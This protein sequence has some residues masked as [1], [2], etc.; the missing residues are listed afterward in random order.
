MPGQD[1]TA[2]PKI[3][4]VGAGPTGLALAL[5]LARSGVGSV[6]LERKAEL[7]PH[8]RATV[9]LP[10]TM[11]ILAQW[12]L[13]EQFAAAGNCVPHIRLRHAPEGKQFA[14]FDFTDLTN[15]TAT[16]F[17]LALP[18]DQTEH[19]LLAAVT[20]TGM[21]DV[22]FNTEVLGFE[23]NDDGV[24]LRVRSSEGEHEL[25][26]TY[27]VGADGAHSVVRGGLGFELE[28]KTYPTRA[29]L[30][31]VRVAPEKD[32]TEFWPCL[33]NE[34]LV[35]GIRF[36]GGIFR[37]VADSVDESVTDETIGDHVNQL[38]TRLFGLPPVETIWQ[39]TYR[40]HQRC[41]PRFR[42]GRVLLAGD[43]A[44]LNSPAGGQGMN[45]GIQDAHN[46]AWKLAMAVSDQRADVDALLESYAEE[47][48]GYVNEVVLPT[49]DAMERFESGPTFLR[50]A[51]VWL[52]DKLLGAGESAPAVARRVS[53]LDVVYGRSA[54]IQSDAPVGLRLPDVIGVHGNR[55]LGDHWGA[56]VL[57]AGY[58]RAAG[59]LGSALGLPV[60]DGDVAALA[61]FF[62]R[63]RFVALVRPD[64]VVAWISSTESIDTVAC[65]AAL[66]L[67]QQPQ[68]VAADR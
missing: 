49:T 13:R 61:A 55:L 45:S 64:R 25:R 24:V 27:L 57:Q 65:F 3:L 51:V 8:S 12:N 54:L 7:D 62:G 2:S 43:A 23:E 22:R 46:L 6:V 32:Q 42:V 53:M 4:I 26:G 33:L 17:A 58:E 60:L 44:H 20:A 41:A 48:W 31:D 52:G 18:Q 19:L 47:R 16:P 39:R 34:G 10:R 63:D 29:M 50:V 40:K 37:V 67:R 15:D 1:N 9:I 66:G 68:S 5:G 59:E 14:H 36:G 30:A 35:V 21:V 38:V 28:G 11:E 56:V